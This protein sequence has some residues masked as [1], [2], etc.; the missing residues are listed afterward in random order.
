MLLNRIFCSCLFNIK[1]LQNYLLPCPFKKFTGLDCPFCGLQRSVIA[2]ITGNFRQSL[3]LYPATVP[4]LVLIILSL[5]KLR[6]PIDKK[7][8][9][10]KCLSIFTG[11]II[12]WAYLMKISPGF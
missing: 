5:V 12:A 1:W 7:N 8:Y 6:A 4:I 10:K 9:L 11:V 3:Y 2:L